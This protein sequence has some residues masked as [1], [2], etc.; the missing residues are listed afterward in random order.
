MPGIT[1]EGHW[2]LRD[3]AGQIV[4]SGG[5]AQ[6]NVA[7][8]TFRVHVLLGHTVSAGTVSAPT[9]FT[10]TFDD[11]MALTVYDDSEQY[12]SFSI[13]PGNWFI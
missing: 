10:L 3:T 2:E 4:D 6:S 7:H 8:E 5:R 12:E 1:V 9:S 13:Q 11:G